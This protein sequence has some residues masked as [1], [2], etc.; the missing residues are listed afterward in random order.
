MAPS[1]LLSATEVV[2]LVSPDPRLPE[3]EFSLAHRLSLDPRRCRELLDALASAGLVRRLGP[4][5]APAY[6]R[7]GSAQTPDLT[8]QW[9][10]LSPHGGITQQRRAERASRRP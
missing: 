3:T 2:A 5:D 7:V 9:S 8:S 6:Y 4:P 10:G 1:P